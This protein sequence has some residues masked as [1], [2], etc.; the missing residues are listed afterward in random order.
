MAKLYFRYGA[1][2]ASK[3]SNALM[4]EYNYRERGQN[5]VILKP[6]LDT[7]EG[8][9]VV[10]SRL[11]I[12]KEAIL[13]F[14]ETD[15]LKKIADINS[16][17]K[18]D[19][20]I[21]DEAQFFSS[22]QVSQLCSIVDELNIPVIAYGL[23][24]DFAGNL[25][26]GSERLLALADT[27]EEIKTVCWCSKKATMNARVIDGVVVKQGQQI[28]IGGNESYI[29]LCRKHWAEGRLK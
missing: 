23:R 8:I 27:I 24:A 26:T 25:F 7:R 11:G 29:A 16:V 15:V 10:K 2:G 13:I 22:E 20:V 6:S 1:M 9:N 28:V 12:G 21:I 17:T 14:P 18:I 19:C 4:V 5:A 3:T